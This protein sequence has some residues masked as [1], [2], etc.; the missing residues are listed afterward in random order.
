MGTSASYSGPRGSNPLIPSWA[1]L[2][3]PGEV[4][5]EAGAESADGEPETDSRGDDAPPEPVSDPLRLTPLRR[6]VRRS[7]RAGGSDDGAMRAAA[8][9]F[10][11]SAM[12]GGERGARRMGSAR[13]AGD[14]MVQAFSALATGGGQALARVLRLDSL[15]GLSTTQVWDRLAEFVCSDGASID[16][17]IVRVAF[18]QTLRLEIENGLGDLL[19][20]NPEQLSAFFERFIGECVLERLSQ[21]GGSL[22]EQNGVSA[23]AAFTHLSTLRAFIVVQVRQR[24]SASQSRFLPGQIDAGRFDAIVNHTLREAITAV[25]DWGAHE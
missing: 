17:A 8:R 12:G 16:E 2:P 22:L 25:G 5:D 11:S 19:E 15:A 10:A 4:P 1:D 7:A 18:F 13:R 9:H 14:R 23:A 21:D 20:A 3:L 24:L 6:A